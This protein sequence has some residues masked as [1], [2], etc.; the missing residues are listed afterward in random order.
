METHAA[1]ILREGLS[2]GESPRW[3]NGRLWYSDFYRRGIYSM[4]V[5]GDERQEHLVGGQPSGLGG[6]PTAIFSACP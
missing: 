1:R 3:H 5:T 6:Y 2:F 4:D